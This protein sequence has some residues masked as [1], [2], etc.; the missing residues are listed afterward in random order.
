M[1]YTANHHL[2]Q[3]VETDRVRMED[4]NGAM[5]QLEKSLNEE[6]AD[7]AAIRGELAADNAAIRSELTTALASMRNGPIATLT[8]RV[9]V[10]EGFK[11]AWGSF[12]LDASKDVTVALP[13]TA[14][15]VYVQSV[16]NAGIDDYL[17]VEGSERSADKVKLRTNS[18]W[19]KRVNSGNSNSFP[20]NANFNYIAFRFHS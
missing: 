8:Q 19:V 6:S 16:D 18:F 4:F 1:T 20:R 9:T 15:A 12:Y 3:W 11:V 7:N 5:G 17:A 2:P 13:F 14:T 10:L